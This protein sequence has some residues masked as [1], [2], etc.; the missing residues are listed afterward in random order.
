MRHHDCAFTRDPG[1]GHFALMHDGNREAILELQ[2]ASAA[3]L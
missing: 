3:P 2:A 1:S